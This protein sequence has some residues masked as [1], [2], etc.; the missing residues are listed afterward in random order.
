MK[1]IIYKANLEYQP[2]VKYTLYIKYTD[3]IKSVHFSSN[4]SIKLMKCEHESLTNFMF[5]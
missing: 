1:I 5:L 2:I 3:S 4:F